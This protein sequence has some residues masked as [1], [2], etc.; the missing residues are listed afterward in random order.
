MKSGAP[1]DKFGV[2]HR[3]LQIEFH[4]LN[5]RIDFLRF[6]VITLWFLVLSQFFVNGM[7]PFN[8]NPM[9]PRTDL[10]CVKPQELHIILC[11]IQQCISVFFYFVFTSQMALLF[12]I[13]I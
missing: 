13:N 10:H 7:S 3:L 11:E 5:S 9:I 2:L 8:Q 4:G 1:P 6:K 12:N